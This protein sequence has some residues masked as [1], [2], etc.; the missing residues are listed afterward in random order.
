VDR[1]DI[2]CVP[3]EYRSNK[4]AYVKDDSVSKNCSRFLKVTSFFNYLH[5]SWIVVLSFSC[6]QIEIGSTVRSAFE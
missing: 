4:V 3:E 1:Y 2:E 5:R 6:V